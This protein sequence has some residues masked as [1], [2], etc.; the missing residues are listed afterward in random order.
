MEK[1]RFGAAYYEE[2]L[3]YDRLDQDVA[4]MKAAGMNTV[5]IAESTWSTC[6]PQEGEFDFSHVIRVMDAMETADIQV[7][8]GTPTYAVPAWMVKRY[9]QVLAETTEGKGKYG[10]RQIMDITNPV[11]RFYAE[12]IIR[13]LM[14]VTAPR[15]CV[16]GFQLDNETKYYDTA[17][18][19]VQQGFQ[20]YLK[21]EFKGDL[22]RLNQAFGLDYWSNRI[23]SW[24]EFP[25]VTGTINGSLKAE[26]DKYRRGLVTEFLA[27]QAKI[28]REYSRKD[29]FLTQNFD[30]DWKGY[31][32]GVQP[33]VNQ[34]QAV[35][36][37]DIAGTDIYHPTQDE[38]T[39]AEIAF[40]GDL[41]RSL[42]QD[43]YLVLETEAQGF[44][45]WTPY[46]GQLRLQ[47]YSH[48][49]SGANGVMY[50]H[51]HSIH[52]SAETYW[53]GVL[54]HDFAE[55]AVYR[56]A[57]VIGE[58]FQ[59]YG[60]HL[61]N[62]KK[63]NQVAIMIS[64]EALTALNCFPIDA[65][66]SNAGSVGYNHIVRWMY[67]TLYRMNV[68]CDFIPVSTDTQHLMDYQM[69]VLPA[70]YAVPNE[71][72]LRLNAYVNQGGCLV[73]SFKTGFA[74]EYVK[75]SHEMQ[76]HIIRDV[77]GVTYHQFTFPKNTGLKSEVIAL[78]DNAQAELFMELLEP[79]TAET[80]ISYDHYNWGK[81]SAVTKNSSGAGCGIYI[82][83]KLP[84]NVLTEVLDIALQ[85]AKIQVPKE[86]VYPV[87][88]RQGKNDFGKKVIYYLNYSSESQT[89]VY[90]G[91]QGTCLFDGRK[92]AEGDE[93]KLK[94]WNLE[95]LEVE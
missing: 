39:G 36:P 34:F 22:T 28:V 70:L 67:D 57:K 87:I 80:L 72:L 25:D 48:L 52:N 47:A 2:Y 13:E 24:E 59:K 19:N 66:A 45:G 12:R 46:E 50:W 37:L 8:I 82:G 79:D 64:N 43:N 10:A 89:V 33:F 44:P 84:G 75:V 1:I 21:Q 23:N 56:E 58:E 4:M 92:I 73:A 65:S 35:Q 77:L 63:Q 18:L 90:H 74:D 91:W 62:L 41:S 60:K 61:V 51:W 78:P 68:E 93:I 31:S 54:S 15:K 40:G 5:R 42:K 55:N 86:T 14:K 76:P 88:V 9:P 29:Q 30:Y 3:P 95:I 53:K 94:P 27:W 49:A 83:C 38:L 20:Q 16:I 81:Y 32:F 6:E 85:E 69:I 17:G 26:F 11:Y 71:T 7:I